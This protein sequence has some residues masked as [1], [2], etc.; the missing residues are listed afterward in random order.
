MTFAGRATQSRSALSAVVTLPAFQNGDTI[1]LAVVTGASAT[2]GS[3][4][5]TGWQPIGNASGSKGP[6]RW[7]SGSA[8]DA[9][10]AVTVPLSTS[11]KVNATALV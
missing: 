3:P 4:S 8:A 5:G 6:L 2:I 7:K 10:P 11:V 1:L 9:G